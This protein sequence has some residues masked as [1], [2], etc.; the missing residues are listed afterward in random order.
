MPSATFEFFEAIAE[1]LCS[2]PS[3]VITRSGFQLNEEQAPLLDN[4]KEETKSATSEQA[5]Q[6]AI[7]KLDKHFKSK[8]ST[9][10]FKYT[11]ETGFFEAL[12]L[13]F[14]QFIMQMR[15]IR[16]IGKRSR[17]FE[18]EVMKKLSGRVTGSLHRVG[19]PRDVK[20]KSSEFNDHLKTLG[21]KGN[22]LLGKEK[23]GGL[24]ILWVLPIGSVPHQP[25]VSVQCKNGEFDIGEGDKSV[26]AGSRSL[27]THAG[28]Q[29]HV[30]V[31]CVLFNDYLYPEMITA[32]P[33]NFVPLGLTDLSSAV[34]FLTT[35]AI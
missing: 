35:V 22:V 8:H 4:L 7:A 27:A 14:L 21:F 5:M 33:L 11:V 17:D 32:K 10:P 15:N 30:H 31:P 23:D 26:G 3:R 19:H 13:P 1:E 16:S 29:G 28:L 18:V 20:R 12:D 6:A 9:I 34:E 2:E 24:D 25:I